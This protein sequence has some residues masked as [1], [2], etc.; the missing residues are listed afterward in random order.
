LL[1]LLLGFAAARWLPLSAA[2]L[3][4]SNE[5]TAAADMPAATQPAAAAASVSLDSAVADAHSSE[6]DWQT[7]AK[8]WAETDPAGFYDWLIRRGRPP[9][10]MVLK[11]LFSA[12]AERDPDAAFRALFNLPSD[13]QRQDYLMDAVMRVILTKPGGLELALKWLPRV[14]EQSFRMSW[15]EP[16]WE[17][18]GSP[19][20]TGQRLAAHASGKGFSILMLQ[21]FGTWW[22]GRDPAAALSWMRSLPPQLRPGAL[23]GIQN[24]MTQKD[25]AAA[26]E[27]L[28]TDAAST[29]ERAEA[30]WPLQALARTSPA[31]A[32]QWWENNVGIVNRT[33][34]RWIF[35]AWNRSDSQAAGAYALAIEDPMLRRKTLDAWGTTAESG[36][37]RDTI[38]RLPESPDRSALLVALSQASEPSEADAAFIRSAV[39]AGGS[40]ITAAT[41]RSIAGHLAEKQPADTFAWAANLPGSLRAEAVTG[42]L[43]A[44]KDP[45]AAAL[46]VEALPDGDLKAGARQVLKTS[47]T[48]PGR[49]K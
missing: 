39:E 44:W 21:F 48:N 49:A 11:I 23:S 2:G 8:A 40:D 20:E 9:G 6:A 37:V 32:M 34:L 5:G 27:Y 26:L 16:P 28:T 38:S 10:D 43:A 47:I 31:A 35:S 22:A 33:G 7:A 19:E 18:F 17:S 24:T 4:E 41:A 46:A 12:W 1:C 30:A 13:F 29:A 45:A 42:V 3:A 15:V 25:P 36:V 14:D